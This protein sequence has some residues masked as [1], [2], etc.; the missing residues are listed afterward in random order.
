MPIVAHEMGHFLGLLDEYEPLSGITPLYPKTPFEGSENSR[1]GLSMK[2]HTR[3]YPWHHYLVLRRY[4][5]PEP[6]SRDP[7]EGLLN[8]P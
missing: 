4:H 8:E 2:P 6:V 3:L 7:F 5:C 1:M